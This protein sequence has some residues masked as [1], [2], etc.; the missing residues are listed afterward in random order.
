MMVESLSTE[1]V[2]DFIKLEN[3]SNF[4]HTFGWMKAIEESYGLKPVILALL[5]DKK[6]LNVIP[7]FLLE[8]KFFGKK[9]VSLPY[10]DYGGLLFDF[11]VDWILKKLDDIAKETDVDYVEIREPNVKFWKHF[12]SF[13]T[14]FKYYTFILNL[15]KPLEE[16]WKSFDKKVRNSIRK[17]EK[18]NVRV[19]EGSRKDLGEFY[20]LYLRTMKKLGS[21]PHSFN[22]FDNV[23]KFCSKNVKL[24]FAEYEDRKIAASIFFLHKKRIYYWKNVSDDEYLHLRPNDLILYRMIEF[25]Q[26]RK[27]ESLDLGRTRVNTGT[28][29]F[30]KRWGGRMEELK[31][32][33]KVYREREI[34]DP[35]VKKFKFLGKIW[36][37]FPT[38]FTRR[39]GPSIRKNFP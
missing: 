1:E 16:I 37:F 5:D 34:P 15:D 8:S 22:F 33:F 25:G 30:K 24:L 21:P 2:M 23:F 36:S 32:F 11:K 35:E 14:E 3:V 18:N 13:K 38:F 7:F 28:F 26:K 31:Y 29:L 4:Y 12:K 10:G 19:I 20:K 27:Y 17:A 9:L 39:V 6:I